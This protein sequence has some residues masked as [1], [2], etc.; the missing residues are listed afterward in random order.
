MSKSNTSMTSFCIYLTSVRTV[1]WVRRTYFSFPFNSD[2]LT[3]QLV[4]ARVLRWWAVHQRT[5]GS[6]FAM[7]VP[8]VTALCWSDTATHNASTRSLGQLQVSMR[9]AALRRWVEDNQC[10]G[11]HIG[12][13]CCG[14]PCSSMLLM[15]NYCLQKVL[16]VQLKF[17]LLF[18]L[19]LLL[20]LLLV[21]L[22]HM[23]PF[24]ILA[25]SFVMS[26]PSI[27]IQLVSFAK[28]PY[29][30]P[31]LCLFHFKMLQRQLFAK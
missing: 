24:L 31:H 5:L 11:I 25:S 23:Y 14:P 13:Q 3:S 6:L 4:N 2:T 29:P 26:L 27:C 17:I 1:S 15:K 9:T 20:L 12:Q 21:L 16:G 18:G 8:R 19:L 22:Y 10:K 28:R 30:K 7:L